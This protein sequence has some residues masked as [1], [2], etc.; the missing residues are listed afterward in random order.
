MFGRIKTVRTALFGMLTFLGVVFASGST[1]AQAAPSSVVVGD[2]AGFQ[3]ADFSKF[4]DG[5]MTVLSSDIVA[6]AAGEPAYCRVVG[7]VG[8]GK[9]NFEL[10]L[11]TENW[12][13][14]F[15]LQGSGGSGGSVNI[16]DCND[17][18]ARN[19]AVAATDLGHVDSDKYW[20]EDFQ[21][22][23]DFSFRAIH[24]TASAGKVLTGA[25]Y[26]RSPHHSYFRGCSSGGRAAM[27]DA[28]RFPGDF[29]GIIAG[30]VGN[31][32]AGAYILP[33]WIMQSNTGP[34]GKT[35]LTQADLGKVTKAVLAACGSG[36]SRQYG[37]LENPLA[38]RFDP[39]TIVCSANRTTD[40]I[41]PVQADFLVKVYDGPRNSKGQPIYLG[42]ERVYGLM[43]GAEQIFANWI[44]KDSDPTHAPDFDSRETWFQEQ[45]F[46]LQPID[47]SFKVADVNFD[48]DPDRI[49][50]IESLWSSSNPDLRALQARGVKI[51][52]YSGLDDNRVQPESVIDYY[53]AAAAISGWHDTMSFFRL[54]MLPGVGHCSGGPGADTIDWLTPMEDWVE[55]GKP[56]SQVTGA[57][58]KGTDVAFH[59]TI[60]AF[61]P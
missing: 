2:C 27:V 48:T 8:P 15:L 51:I 25:F 42:G 31:P 52:Q 17:V 20:T 55:H 39:H 40:C 11:P 28:E 57:H 29:D 36:E 21:K 60:H 30:D 19:Y 10:R 43:R 49:N 23:V 59:W 56:P 24:L 41:T 53:R 32:R 16:S 54:F 1:W 61:R 26:G 34:D 6:A 14:R 37:F 44:S 7:N 46:F 45:A 5:P 35:I 38:C 12:N 3:K 33:A 13:G 22:L 58:M 50:A 9:I 47:R 18:L 4:A